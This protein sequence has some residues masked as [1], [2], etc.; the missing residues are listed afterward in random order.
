MAPGSKATNPSFNG[1]TSALT[2]EPPPLY[3][4]VCCKS[5]PSPASRAHPPEVSSA[6]ANT[7]ADATLPRIGV[8]G[9]ANRRITPGPHSQLFRGARQRWQIGSA[10]PLIHH[11]HM[12]NTRTFL[13][14][15][16]KRIATSAWERGVD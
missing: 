12:S 13:V 9:G 11:T 3:M 10:S 16:L 1:Y 8:R 14:R 7:Q 2:F 15:H 4:S 6:A 5:N